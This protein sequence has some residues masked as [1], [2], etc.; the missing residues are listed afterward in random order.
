MDK[1]FDLGIELIGF[2]SLMPINDFCKE[3]FVDFNKLNL[4]SDRFI[5]TKE[6]KYKNQCKCNNY[7]YIP[8]KIIDKVV[9]VYYKN[10]FK[11]G[12]LFHGIIYDGEYLKTGF[13]GGEIIK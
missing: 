4:D 12:K 10:T 1:S 9:R 7:L 11:P 3:N 6:F 13:N 5:M 8:E 2:V